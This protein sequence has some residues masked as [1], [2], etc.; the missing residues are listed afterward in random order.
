MTN[1]ELVDIVFN[2]IDRLGY[3]IINIT[4]PDGYFIFEGAKDS[5]THFEVRGKGMWH[6]WR[7]GL[8]VHSEYM[9][10]ESINNTKTKRDNGEIVYG[11]EPKAIQLFAQYETNI[12][13]FKPSR[14]ALLVEYDAES[15]LDKLKTQKEPPKYNPNFNPF[16][17]I[18][19]MLK[20]MHRHPFMCYCEYCGCGDYRS[21]YGDSFIY[22]FIKYETQD[23]LCKLKKFV[24]TYTILPY[25]Y[26][27]LFF[28]KFDKCISDIEIHNF[29]KEN[30]GWRTNYL[31]NIIPIFTAECKAEDEVNWLNK[32][33][34]KDHYGEYGCYDY[35]VEISSCK[36]VG[37]EGSYFYY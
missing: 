6:K 10:E 32:W 36:K 21:Y 35:I 11:Q 25:T 30:E 5:V 37:K 16:Y 26:V 3:K 33:F 17:E 18:E 20:M 34:H 4:H 19:N 29:E 13:K 24:L 9:T 22:E 27:K 23:K 12:D 14:S 31:Y 28:A 7:F 8:W 1:K 15:L 2:E